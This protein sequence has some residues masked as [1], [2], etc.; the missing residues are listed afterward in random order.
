LEDM[1]VMGYV[2]IIEDSGYVYR[3]LKS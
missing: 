3:A 2:P 1:H